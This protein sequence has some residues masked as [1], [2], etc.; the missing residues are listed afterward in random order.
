M[1]HICSLNCDLYR[2]C[3]G[4]LKQKVHNKTVDNKHSKWVV[5]RVEIKT[6]SQNEEKEKKTT[7]QI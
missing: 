7:N 2:N 5:E 4:I 3:T 1:H 6:V